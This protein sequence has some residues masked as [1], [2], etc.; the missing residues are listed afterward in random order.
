MLV[1]PI[2]PASVNVLRIGAEKWKRLDELQL[3]IILKEMMPVKALLNIW[4]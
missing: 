3:D 4:H 2:S 1:S